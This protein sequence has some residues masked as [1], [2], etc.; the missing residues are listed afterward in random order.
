[1]SEWIAN[2]YPLSLRGYTQTKLPEMSLNTHLNYLHCWKMLSKNQHVIAVDGNLEI[3]LEMVVNNTIEKYQSN[4]ITDATFRRYRASICLGLALQLEKLLSGSS[5]NVTTYNLPALDGLYRKIISIEKHSGSLKTSKRTSGL[6]MKYFPKGLYDFIQR[7]DILRSN[8][9]HL[10][11]LFL[12]ANVL[13]GLRPIEWRT[14][15]FACNLEK[16]VAAIV[17][18][19]GKNSHGRANGDQRVLLLEKATPSQ[20]ERL[21][22]F[23]ATF[24]RELVERVEAVN[25]W[26]DNYSDSGN[27]VSSIASVGGESIQ[28]QSDTAL[29]QKRKSVADIIFEQENSLDQ[30]KKI[31]FKEDE[32]RLIELDSNSH[33][34][35]LLSRYRYDSLTDQY[36]NPAYGITE[37]CLRSMQRLLNTLDQQYWQQRIHYL[38]EEKAQNVTLYSTRHQC[39]ANAKAAKVPVV[40]IAAFFG[41]ASILTARR[42]YGLAGSAWGDKFT[43]RPSAE[44]ISAVHGYKLIGARQTENIEDNRTDQQNMTSD[45]DDKNLDEWRNM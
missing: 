43:F 23:R 18:D 29:Y 12:Q 39:I 15:C 38:N 25:E 36:G 21:W 9:R 30:N 6:K 17:V 16:K 14:A 13:V 27:T 4:Q 42:H 24:L 45:L 20:L 2:R 32:H 1:M 44:S 34:Y 28:I 31:L 40:Q 19:N 26:L 5:P 22:R 3:N 8:T 35:S 33:I 37:S 7:Q 11:K 10:L 41:H